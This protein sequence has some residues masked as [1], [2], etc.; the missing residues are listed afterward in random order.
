MWLFLNDQQDGFLSENNQPISGGVPTWCQ[1]T[2][3]ST[4]SMVTSLQRREGLCGQ[5]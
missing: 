5:D 3:I 4:V 2:D 1:P